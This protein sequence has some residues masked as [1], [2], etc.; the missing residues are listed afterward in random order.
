MALVVIYQ[1][2]SCTQQ[3]QDL[4]HRTVY[5]TVPGDPQSQ[6]SIVHGK[7]CL[8]NQKALC[9]GM[10]EGNI[11]GGLFVPVAFDCVCVFMCVYV[12]DICTYVYTCVETRGVMPR[13]FLS[14][15]TLLFEA[16]C[17]FEPRAYQVS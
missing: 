15:S 7:T 3:R 17:L 12:P 4:G 6:N 8:Y 5:R 14:F 2:S 11:P 16:E 1:K 13:V 9:F 10:A